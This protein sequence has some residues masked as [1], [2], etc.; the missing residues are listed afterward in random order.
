M[1]R[2]VSAGAK[3]LRFFSRDK[4]TA[5]LWVA[6]GIVAGIT[7]AEVPKGIQFRAD[8]YNRD[9]GTNMLKGKGN[10]WIKSEG[11]QLWADEIEVDFTT[12]RGTAVG[13]VHV[14]DGEINIYSANANFNLK[15]A[16]AFFDKATLVSGQVVITGEVIRRM[17][18]Q[19]FEV[20]EGG[21]SNCNIDL[22]KGPKVS[23]C[24]LDWGISGRRF[25]VTMG[26]YAHFYD[27][28]V[29]AKRIPLL[30]AP[31]IILPVKTDRQT[32]LLMPSFIGSGTL[33]SGF[34][35]P[36]FWAISPWQDLLVNPTFYSNSGLHTAFDYRYVYSGDTQ[37]Y[38]SVYFVTRKFGP[39]SNPGPIDP[40]RPRPLG[41]L[42]EGAVRAHN[43]YQFGNTRAHSRQMITW[44]S[45][46]YYTFDYAADVGPRA[47]LGNL[48]SQL[49]LTQ[50]GDSWLFTG[51]AQYLQSLI[52][53]R[54]SG[55]DGGTPAQLPILN[56]AKTTA[57]LLGQTLSYEFDSQFTNFTRRTAF[58]QVPSTPVDAQGQNTDTDPAFDSDDYLRTGQRLQ[59][60]PRLILNAPMPEGFQF[61]PLLRAGSLAYHFNVPQSAFRHREYVD[62][63]LPF[64]MQLSRVFDTSITG[65]EKVS[66]IFQPRFIYGSSLW[67]SG[68]NDH[69]FF[70]NA[71]K[72][73]VLPVPG[74]P[75]Q[76][77]SFSNPRFD[78][79]DQ[80]TP[81][82]Y[83]RFELINRFQRRLGDGNGER[84]FWFQLSEQYNLRTS[85]IDP[86]YRT[87]LGPLELFSSFNYGDFALQ[88][89][90][91]FPVEPDS[92]EKVISTGFSYKGNGMDRVAVNGL[93]RESTLDY[94]LR[95]TTL[96]L[97]F[98]KTLPTFFDLD[99]YVEYNFLTH[100][101]YA[102]RIGFHF[103]SKPRSCW[104]F[105][106]STGRNAYKVAVTQIG[107]N[108][109]FGNVSGL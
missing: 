83:M 51:Q 29:K 64:A 34:S 76:D 78:I 21:Y 99:G 24:P 107:F 45:N 49:S 31:Y 103:G 33:G 52:V 16:D 81:Y 13:N 3:G 11:R 95:A 35:L 10:A 47:E 26:A 80:I 104:T 101:F 61:Q 106:L 41:F 77:A 28:L 59:L 5:G 88:V 44:V 12:N 19:N 60:E 18:V 62:I 8:Y 85:N 56:A 87:R 25:R 7:R 4:F 22:L 102:Y 100:E 48:R 96:N 109:R 30:Y 17:D 108:L 27:V 97:T 6:F 74:Q 90:G 38:A 15:G 54:D 37:G 73:P 105:S 68:G 43:I 98:Y 70:T 50:P 57:P 2:L 55:V 89:T 72:V 40:T 71:G 36:F 20:E 69:P 84:F 1:E 53:A 66:H 67:Q 39:P 9:L 93:H 91:A 86:R 79:V 14:E 63:E 58:D 42:G 75:T 23:E 46:P 32:G 65:F 82:E 92:H 94:G